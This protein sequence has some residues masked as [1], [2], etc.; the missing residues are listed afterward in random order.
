MLNICNE[1]RVHLFIVMEKR[2]EYMKFNKAFN[3]E[4]NQVVSIVGAGGKTSLMFKLAEELRGDNR[5]AITTTTK[6]YKPQPNEYDK[7]ILKKHDDLSYSFR[8][9]RQCDNGLY[10]I[11]DDVNNDNK[12]TGLKD[13]DIEIIAQNFDYTF[14]ESDGAKRKLLKA[15]RE[16]EPVISKSTTKTIGVVNIK[17]LGMCVNSENIHR[18]DKF[19][20]L[21]GGKLQKTVSIEDL[22]KII[23]YENGLF[24]NSLGE[25]IV[26]FN[27]IGLSETMKLPCEIAFAAEK[28]KKYGIGVVVGDTLGGKI[29]ECYNTSLR[30]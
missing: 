20:A 23:C 15:W 26:Y 8:N 18:V 3:I 24:H 4:K 5:V 16:D 30:K 22:I 9:L 12:L 11:A 17:S 27:G 29:Y 19:L 10:V 2:V 25:N 6:I 7:L 21:T 13:D 1:C 14:I 28:L